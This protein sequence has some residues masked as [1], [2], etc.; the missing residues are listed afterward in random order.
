MRNRFQRCAVRSILTIPLASFLLS[1][2]IAL[3]GPLGSAVSFAVLGGATVTDIGL[4][5]I[6]GNLGLSG[7]SISG[8][9][10]I[11]ITGTEHF[12]DTAAQTALTDAA[13]A[14][15]TLAALTVTQNETGTNLGGLT[16]TPGV[17]SF[18]A[19]AA[20]TTGT[21]PTLTLDAG[22]NLNAVFVFKIVTTLDTAAGSVVKVINGNAGTE[23]FWLV[24]SS[25][26][27]GASS[28]FV[29]NIIA[30]ASIGV[31]TN[32]TICGRTLAQNAT[33]T[34]T[35]DTNTVADACSAPSALNSGLGDF[36]SLGFAGNTEESV[37]E[38][39][40]VPLLCLGL[41]ALTL[42]GWQS[43]KRVA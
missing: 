36:G 6:K 8:S 31:G 39:G 18:D 27:L 9:G 30:L 40:T 4:N 38:T 43:R 15:S 23:V 1:P 42:Y 28:T 7:L 17:Y 34:V 3:A 5:T 37:P 10:T 16:L 21:T 32:A 24:G 14:Y 33:M 20:L 25:A 22:N 13:N 12:N 35:L 29:G 41:L 19:T 11:A 2:S 26:T